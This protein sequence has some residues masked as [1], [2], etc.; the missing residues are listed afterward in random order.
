MTKALP[1]DKTCPRC[2]TRFPLAEFLTLQG[3]G[4]PRTY[5]RPCTQTFKSESYARNAEKVKAKVK[6]YVNQNKERVVVYQDAYRAENRQKLNGLAKVYRQEKAPVI[7][8]KDRL[9]KLL[10]SD[11]LKKRYY[12]ASA[13]RINSDPIKKSLVRQRQKIS[14][15]K[16]K[17]ANPGKALANAAHYHAKRRA[18]IKEGEDFDFYSYKHQL[19]KWQRGRCFHCL[20][21]L[22]KGKADVDH[23]LP[24]A[25]NGRH[26]KNNLVLS[27]EYCNSSKWSKLYLKEWLPENRE[28]HEIFLTDQRFESLGCASA[29]LVST[30]SALDRP[31]VIRDYKIANPEI[32]LFLDYE[33]W[34]HRTAVETY[35]KDKQG[36]SPK[37]GA[38][39][40]ELVE[41]E[42][43]EA[44]EF[45][46]RYHLQGFGP[47]A[48]YLGLLYGNRLVACT[49][50][51]FTKDHIELNRMAFAGRVVGGFSK[52]L[53]GFLRHPLNTGQ[54]ILSYVDPRYATG[55]S[56][57]KV[58]FTYAGQSGSPLYYYVTG[59]G[60]HQRQRFMKSRM[61]EFLEH[62][63][64]ELTEYE[65]AK[66]H[67]YFRVTCLSQLRFMFTQEC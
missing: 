57:L 23:F 22:E 40:T 64:S 55:R 67:G 65:N 12:Q 54:P 47:G 9:R 41:V 39:Q 32:M 18:K 51:R 52:L 63:D 48:L 61:S 53:Q 42:T 7:R 8:E 33:W 58:G 45:F 21:K 46:N 20:K 36:L 19:F 1:V 38:R 49:A 28:V 66:I 16:W 56:Y 50:W 6:A 24:L 17:D 35:I 10:L 34:K 4:K 29:K 26:E 62:F 60:L 30:F 37:I 27:C 11:E 14:S 43:D 59:T 44:R 5:C 31:H 3:T 25:R 13:V 15:K 2:Q